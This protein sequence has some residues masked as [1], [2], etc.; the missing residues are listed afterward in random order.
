PFRAGNRSADGV[1]L[2][3]TGRLMDEKSFCRSIEEGAVGKPSAPFQSVEVVFAFDSP[4]LGYILLPVNLLERELVVQTAEFGLH[5]TLEF[6]LGHV[7]VDGHRTLI[8]TDR[9]PENR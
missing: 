3:G 7:V 6:M 1:R 8:T 4:L 2:R 5:I 9:I